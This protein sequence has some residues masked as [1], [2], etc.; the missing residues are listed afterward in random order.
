M[1]PSGVN[2]IHHGD[3]RRPLPQVGR[4][5][6]TF[7]PA[8]VTVGVLTACS[9]GSARSVQ[10]PQAGVQ[11]VTIGATDDF[12]FT[13][14]DVSVHPGK[15]RLTL[16]DRGAYPHNIAFSTLGPTSLGPTSLGPTSLG[17]TSASVSGSPGQT[18]TTLTLTFTRPGRYDFVC[19]YHS[20]AGMKGSLVV[21][22][23]P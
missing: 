20:S 1:N 9:S 3:F 23:Q 16:V 7:A 21:L 15:V 6:I 10:P 5:W 17:A 14:G 18:S 4:K 12:R 19:T 22:K 11:A 2:V 8:V 13:P